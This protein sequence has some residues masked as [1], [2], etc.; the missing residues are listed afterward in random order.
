MT[1]RKPPYADATRNEQ[2]IK[3]HQAGV[4]LQA[5]GNRYG[6]TRERVRQILAQAGVKRSCHATWLMNQPVNQI[7]TDFKNG[8][9]GKQISLKMG[10][11]VEAVLRILHEAGFK[12]P[13]S[14]GNPIPEAE[15]IR[16]YPTMGYTDLAKHFQVDWRRIK[17]LGRSLGLPAKKG[18]RW[19]Y[20][21]R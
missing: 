8:L 12:T 13:S 5:I 3:L 11:S 21:R 7:V 6:L 1:P 10:L 15:L 9:N 20:G 19:F 2:I 18:G 14:I 17:A 4:T 16:L